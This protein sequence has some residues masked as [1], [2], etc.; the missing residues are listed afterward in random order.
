MAQLAPDGGRDQHFGLDLRSEGQ[1]GEAL[2]LG[3]VAALEDG[4]RTDGDALR[5]YLEGI[6]HG[7]AAD[8]FR[9]IA[10]VSNGPFPLHRLSSSKASPATI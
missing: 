3:V 6:P 1:I 4:T 5:E 10:A 8:L 9:A 7:I 2:A